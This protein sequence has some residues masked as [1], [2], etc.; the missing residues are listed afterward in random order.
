MSNEEEPTHDIIDDFARLCS[1]MQMRIRNNYKHIQE[2]RRNN[3]NNDENDELQIIEIITML[4]QKS[5]RLWAQREAYRRELLRRLA[6]LSMAELLAH[7][8][9]NPD[10]EPKYRKAAMA[11]VIYTNMLVEKIRKKRREKEEEEKKQYDWAQMLRN[12]EEWYVLSPYLD[13]VD[14]EDVRPF[15]QHEVKIENEHALA[16]AEGAHGRLGTDSWLRCIDLNLLH[17]IYT[18]NKAQEVPWSKELVQYPYTDIFFT[19]N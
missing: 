7:A 9:Q 4:E 1:R 6:R 5:K 19:I 10:L 13:D 3:H 8:H 16:F 2:L 14:L 18:Q 17:S 12:L 15:L 11:R